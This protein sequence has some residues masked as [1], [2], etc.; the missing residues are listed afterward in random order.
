MSI[1][2][3]VKDLLAGI[4]SRA[5]FRSSR[6]SAFMADLGE[7]ASFAS[8]IRSY[9]PDSKRYS[10]RRA[11]I[12]SIRS[13]GLEK[14]K[15][16]EFGVASGEMAFFIQRCF[17]EYDF[18]YTGFDCFTGLPADWFRNGVL[19]RPRD[20]F[21][22]NGLAPDIRDSRFSFIKGLVEERLQDIQSE[23]SNTDVMVYMFDL[24]LYPPTRLVFDL[25]SPLLK[26]GDYIYFD[27][28]FDSSNE[29]RL[30]MESVLTDSR[31]YCVGHST[32][33]TLFRII[34]QSKL[35]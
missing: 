20:F 23:V 6:F 1:Q 27:E 17:K 34:G 9:Y 30:I 19:Y 4:V 35:N 28:A 26:Q 7:C 24:D 10:S 12:S 3:H 8:F 5:L 11:L 13:N 29:R 32:I 16:L 2:F 21:N 31:F 18:S 33:G 25:L 15:F 22:T 14:L